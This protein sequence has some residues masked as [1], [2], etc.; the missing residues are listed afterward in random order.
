MLVTVVD[1]RVMGMAVAQW[2]VMVRMSVRLDSVPI[3]IVFVLVVLVVA[4]LVQVRHWQVFVLMRMR[5]AQM[6]PNAAGHQRGCNPEQP[7]RDFAQHR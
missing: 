6:Q 3:R 7:A 4:V 2:C 1:V 5:L